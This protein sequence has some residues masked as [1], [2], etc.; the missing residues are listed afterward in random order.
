M[1][2]TGFIKT[3]ERNLETESKA[4][5][6]SCIIIQIGVMTRFLRLEMEC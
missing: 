4:F 3:R 1:G 2:N 6:L 5:I